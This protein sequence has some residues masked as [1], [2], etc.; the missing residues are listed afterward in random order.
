MD[1]DERRS[2]EHHVSAV[3][4]TKKHEAHVISLPLHPSYCRVIGLYYNTGQSVHCSSNA[5]V[6]YLGPPI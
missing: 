5:C 4:T 3:F 6:L 2:P 1:S